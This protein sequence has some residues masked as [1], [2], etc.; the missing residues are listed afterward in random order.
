MPQKQ[1]TGSRAQVMQGT[2]KKTTGGLTKSQ[3]KYNKQGKIVSKKASALATKNNRLV[4]AGYITRKGEFGVQMRGGTANGSK[5]IEWWQ[6]ESTNSNNIES[7][8]T[9]RYICFFLD[10]GVLE[11]VITQK[12]IK[13]LTAYKEHFTYSG[14]Q[15]PSEIQRGIDKARNT[16]KQ[17]ETNAVKTKIYFFISPTPEDEKTIVDKLFKKTQ[18]I[19]LCTIQGPVKSDSSNTNNIIMTLRE[20]CDMTSEEKEFIVKIDYS[21]YIEIIE[22]I[23]EVLSTYQM[24]DKTILQKFPCNTLKK[25]DCS[26]YINNDGLFS[27]KYSNKCVHRKKPNMIRKTK[28]DK[29]LINPDQL[30]FEV[31]ELNNLFAKR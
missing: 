20:Q 21:D 28:Y 17:L 27:C 31:A 7:K 6:C 24:L 18:D 8:D 9:R 25:V 5:D 10:D 16:I 3:L 2:A 23:R 13:D 30:K 1:T 12:K 14:T 22:R 15:P 29:K 26:G 11:H 19:F 4:K